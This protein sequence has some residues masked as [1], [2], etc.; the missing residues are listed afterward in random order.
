MS[1]SD[2]GEAAIKRAWFLVLY[3]PQYDPTGGLTGSGIHINDT[4]E[5]YCNFYSLQML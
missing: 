4:I 1:Y 2:D 3:S 5:V